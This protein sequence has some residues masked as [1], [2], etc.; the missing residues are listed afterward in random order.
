[1]LN[2]GINKACSK[3]VLCLK[4]DL[5]KSTQLKAY[6][7]CSTESL[8]EDWFKRL[9]YKFSG[10]LMGDRQ[11]RQP[12]RQ[13]LSFHCYHHLC[14]LR[15]KVA[16]CCHIVNRHGYL[17][18]YTQNLVFRLLTRNGTCNIKLNTKFKQRA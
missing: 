6:P 5:K 18:Y 9:L 16:G 17:V 7:Y 11:D 3:Q 14:R 10:Y 12:L 8:D 13:P 15:F 2:T 4:T 1:M